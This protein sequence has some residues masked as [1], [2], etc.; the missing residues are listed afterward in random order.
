MSTEARDEADERAP[1][2][3]TLAL[4][5]R[6]S[7]PR[8]VRRLV[9]LGVAAVLALV[10][11]TAWQRFK[12]LPDFTLEQ[13]QGAYAGMVRADGTN[14]VSTIDPGKFPDPPLTVD[15]V[16]CTPLFATTVSNQWPR[17]AVDGVSTYWL[18]G[19]D[20]VSLFTVR[21]VDPDAAA[22]AYREVDDAVTAC[23]GQTIRFS[24]REGSG[25]LQRVPVAPGEHAREQLAYRLDRAGGQGRYVLHLLRLDNTVSW[26]YRYQAGADAYDPTSAEQMMEGLATQLLSVRQAAV[27]AAG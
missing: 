15:P 18:A 10:G 21:Y 2:P 7:D 17:P 16:G 19:P 14:D 22:A 26:Q 20:S 27:K 9:A 6:S 25:R 12:P 24:G 13:L 5:P 3:E 4:G 8:L 11:W 1:E 23:E